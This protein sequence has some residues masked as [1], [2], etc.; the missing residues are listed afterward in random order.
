MPPPAISKLYNLA[1]K[2]CSLT[3]L[4]PFALPLTILDSTL[5][6]EISGSLSPTCSPE[7]GPVDG[8]DGGAFG[9]M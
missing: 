5:C 6:F 7:D 8:P 1:R 3:T 2:T 4:R 9:S